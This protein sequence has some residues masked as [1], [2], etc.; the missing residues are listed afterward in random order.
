MEMRFYLIKAIRLFF[1]QIDVII[2]HIGN[3]RK[4]E[5]ESL[6]LFPCLLA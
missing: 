5:W 4:Y 2:F 6:S 1:V 3:V